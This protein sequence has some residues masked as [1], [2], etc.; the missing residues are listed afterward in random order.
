M[1]HN[2]AVSNEVAQG[3]EQ[4]LNTWCGHHHGFGDPRQDGDERRYATTGIHQSLE[5]SDALTTS[6][7]GRANLGDAIKF[8]RTTG[9]FKVDDTKSDIAQRNSDFVKSFLHHLSVPEQMFYVKYSGEE[10]RD[11]GVRVVL[12]E[13]DYSLSVHLVWKLDPF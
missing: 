6:V 2:H 5:R 12:S 7:F 8:G 13:H 4:G 3:S 1:G 9:C 10:V 11:R